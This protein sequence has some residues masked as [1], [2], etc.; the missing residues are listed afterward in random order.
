MTHAADIDL[1]CWD[2][3]DTL[4]DERFMRIPPPDVPEWT[5]VYDNYLDQHPAWDE[6]WMLGKASL[7]DLIAPLAD[8]LPMTRPEVSHHLRAVWWQIEWY[9]EVRAWLER[10]NGEMLQA[11]VTVNPWEFEGIAAA[12]GLVP[13]VDVIVTSAEVGSASKV[14]MAR[15]AR[16]LLGLDDRL[17]A[18][19]LIDNRLDNVEEFRQSGGRAFHFTRQRF[20]AEAETLFA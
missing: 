18:T 4:V 10:L 9:P 15:R 16:E 17:D 19:L 3:G 5:D 8:Q 13:L 20:A 2:F 7:N 1:V 6:A 14:V 11:V 12:C